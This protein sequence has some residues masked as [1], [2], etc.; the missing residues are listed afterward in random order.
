MTAM[1]RSALERTGAAVESFAEMIVSVIVMV[2]AHPTFRE[3]GGTWSFN[4]AVTN[5]TGDTSLARPRAD[6]SVLTQEGLKWQHY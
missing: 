5:W 2:F 6:E 1:L 4:Q 3:L